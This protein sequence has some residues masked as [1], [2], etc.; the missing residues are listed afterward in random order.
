MNAS[1]VENEAQC[2]FARLD[3]PRLD[4]AFS[5][6]IRTGHF[7]PKNGVRSHAVALDAHTWCARSRECVAKWAAVHCLWC[8]QNHPVASA[9]LDDGVEVFFEIARN[10]D[11]LPCAELCSPHYCEGMRQADE[12]YASRDSE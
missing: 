11:D 4:P 12:I 5:A 7:S 10:A 9:F 2:K 3:A 8:N 6:L 1:K